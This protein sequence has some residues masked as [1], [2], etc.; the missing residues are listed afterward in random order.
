VLRERDLLQAEGQLGRHQIGV[1]DFVVIGRSDRFLRFIV[2]ALTTFH[3]HAD[4]HFGLRSGVK[5]P[6]VF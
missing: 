6:P 5:M 4:H 1:Q 2:K 3:V